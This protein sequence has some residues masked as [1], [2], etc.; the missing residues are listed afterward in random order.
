VRRYRQAIKHKL[1][2]EVARVMAK[3]AKFT[4]M[5]HPSRPFLPTAPSR[6]CIRENE[7]PAELVVA[8]S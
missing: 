8:P 2:L 6:Q 7:E 3:S 5:T 4:P 1:T